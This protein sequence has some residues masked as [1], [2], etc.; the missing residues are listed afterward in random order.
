MTDKSNVTTCHETSTGNIITPKGVVF[1][2]QY[3]TEPHENDQGKL[4][5]NLELCFPPETDLK[6]L[7][8]AMAKVALENLDG[9][10]EAAKKYVEQRFLDPNGLESGKP[11]GKEFTG[12]V[13][14][15]ASSDYMPDF[16]Y[17]NG[18][19]CPA[20]SLKNECYSG[21]WLRATVNPYWYNVGKKRGVSLGLQNIQLLDQGTPIGFKKPEGED[22]FGAVEGA[23]A[24]ETSKASASKSDQT[25]D[26]LFG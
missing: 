18:K 24:I 12:W 19:K 2:A 6:L 7:K 3:L 1:Y 5:Y 13:M 21:R 25:V 22:E 4:K 10:R 20:E 14:I 26:A 23:A 9:D 17:P 8:N 11:R 15:R 16:I